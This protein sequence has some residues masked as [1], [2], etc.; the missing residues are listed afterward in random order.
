MLQNIKDSVENRNSVLHN[1]TVVAHAVSST[2]PL[3]SL[4][5]DVSSARDTEESEALVD[6]MV[7]TRLPRLLY[8]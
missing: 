4:P 1:A 5:H 3:T 2:R 6:D 8:R 7:A